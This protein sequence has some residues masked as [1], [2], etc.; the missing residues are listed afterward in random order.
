MTATPAVIRVTRRP[1]TVRVGK[2]E[3]PAGKA[4]VCRLRIRDS[5]IGLIEPMNSGVKESSLID[6]LRLP[7]VSSLI[8]CIQRALRTADSSTLRGKMYQRI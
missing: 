6:A 2:A 7:S 4:M 1:A 5:L 3:F 8:R